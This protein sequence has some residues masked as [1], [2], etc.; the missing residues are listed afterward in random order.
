MNKKEK[1]INHIK[2][3]WSFAQETSEKSLNLK[4]HVATNVALKIF[5]KCASPFHYFSQETKQEEKPT[6]KQ[7]AYAKQLG[8]ENPE[9]YPKKILR[10]KITEVVDHE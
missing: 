6:E 2:E 5:E 4:G 8:I 10:Q 7:L 1:Y 3:S 9:S